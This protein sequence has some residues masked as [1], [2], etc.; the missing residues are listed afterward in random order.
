MRKNAEMGTVKSASLQ[1]MNL[2]NLIK[3]KAKERNAELIAK[4]SKIQSQIDAEVN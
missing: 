2:R 1:V 4:A 3:L